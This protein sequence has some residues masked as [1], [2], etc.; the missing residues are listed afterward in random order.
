MGHFNSILFHKPGPANKQRSYQ[1]IKKGATDW[2]T[3]QS[4]VF[5]E[6]GFLTNLI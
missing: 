4:M 2:L 1:S 5:S 6:E 3:S